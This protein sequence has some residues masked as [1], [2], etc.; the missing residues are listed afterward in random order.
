MMETLFLLKLL[1]L[2]YKETPIVILCGDRESFDFLNQQTEGINILRRPLSVPDNVVKRNDYHR[3][4]AILLKFKVLKYSINKYGTSCF[5]DCDIVPLQEFTGPEDCIV[6]LSLNLA[7]TKDL[8]SSVAFEGLFNAGIV[9]S[10]T[11][12]FIDWWYNQYITNKEN[13]FYEQ[14]CLNNVPGNFRTSYFDNGHNYGF[15]RGMI[16]DR[17]PR[18]LHVHLQDTLDKKM[19]QFMQSKIKRFREESVRYIS[20]YPKV[21]QIYKELFV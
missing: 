6:G 10:S 16:N 11:N 15:W 2:L 20:Q 9:Y 12:H 8:K 5:L 3:P 13:G 14:K 19:P 4:D 17:Q 7:N 18:S 21:H 1:R